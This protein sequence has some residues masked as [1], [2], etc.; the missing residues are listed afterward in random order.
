ME[1]IEYAIAEKF[2][3]IQGE[4]FWAGSPMAFVRLSGC[5]V[6]KIK[7]IC[8]SWNG[9]PFICDTGKSYASPGKVEHHAYTEINERLTASDIWAWVESTRCSTLLLT[10]GEPLAY[11]LA[12]F[13]R[14]LLTRPK[15][16][17]HIETSGTESSTLPMPL[18]FPQI[19]IT[20]SPKTLGP[21]P[22]L[23]V[24]N[25][26]KLLVGHSDYATKILDWL[27][28]NTPP[29]WLGTKPIYL[30]PTEY[31]DP[32]LTR[33]ATKVAIDTVLFRPDVF[34]LSVQ[35]H[36]YLGVR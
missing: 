36:K 28:E 14:E 33:Y 12:P 15:Y 23:F 22:A 34:R 10:G 35:T 2:V 29:S 26:L 31:S 5:P 30:Q 20:V 27:K 4:G 13:C 21:Y 6:G 32:Q 7:G 9:E 3:S 8:C 11:D 24:A 19:W 18:N 16:S 25:E 1:D 17:L